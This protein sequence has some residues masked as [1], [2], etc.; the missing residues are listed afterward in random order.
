MATAQ[1]AATPFGMGIVDGTSQ[2][3]GGTLRATGDIS[4]QVH[5]GTADVSFSLE[6]TRAL[7]SIPV[8]A[9]VQDATITL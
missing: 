1:D 8:D 7:T 9:A 2:I 4:V 6:R 3:V 5:G